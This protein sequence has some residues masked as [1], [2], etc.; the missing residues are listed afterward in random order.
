M[1]ILHRFIGKNGDLDWEGVEKEVYEDRASVLGSRR[2]LIGEADGASAYQLRY[3]EIPPGGKS[4]MD[5]HKHDHGIYILRGSSRILLGEERV[6]A[7][8]VDVIYIPS[9]ERHQLETVGDAPLGFLCI[10]QPKILQE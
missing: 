5:I 6:E 10:S 4:S 8:I 3:F 1:G 9:N 7:G 2:I